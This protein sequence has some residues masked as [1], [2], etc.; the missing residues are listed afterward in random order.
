MADIRSSIEGEEPEIEIDL[1]EEQLAEKGL[2]PAMVGQSLRNLI[3]GDI[4]T[5]MTVED[6]KTDVKLQLNMDDISSLDQ[7][8]KQEINNMMGMPV[9]L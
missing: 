4:V 5:S 2:M 9:A 8:G 3:N 7:L 1:D 6:E